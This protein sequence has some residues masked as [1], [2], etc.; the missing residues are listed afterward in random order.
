MERSNGMSWMSDEA[1]SKKKEGFQE[2]EIRCW[3]QKLV[4]VHWKEQSGFSPPEYLTSPEGGARDDL[5]ADRRLG[6][7][8][9]V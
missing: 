1:H 6:K 7:S 2:G 3:R 9:S 8:R 5:D 4:R